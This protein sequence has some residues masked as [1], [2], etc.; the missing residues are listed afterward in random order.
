MKNKHLLWMVSITAS[1]VLLGLVF[2]L[3]GLGK[4]RDL[5]EV[6]YLGVLIVIF[7]LVIVPVFIKLLRDNREGIPFNDERS[8]RIKMFAAGNAY[9]HSFPLWLGLLAF[10][11]HFDQDDLLMT[12]LAGM[13]ILFGI[14]WLYMNRKKGFTE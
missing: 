7:L 5:T 13:V 12:G 3:I 10:H 1:L 2:R 4:A 8:N 6:Y 11:K 9:F 14:N